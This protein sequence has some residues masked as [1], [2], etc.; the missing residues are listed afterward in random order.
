MYIAEISPPVLRG[1]FSAVPQLGLAIGILLVYCVEA[2]PGSNFSYTALV[3]AAIT[4]LFGLSSLLLLETPRY[5]VKKGKNDKAAVNLKRLRGQYIDIQIE[6]EDTK[7]ILYQET[8]VTMAKFLQ[9]LRNKSVF[10]PLLLLLFVLSFQ[11][12]SGINPLIFYAAPILEQAHVSR[13][14]FTALLA[15]G[16][17]EV[18]TT[19]IT[20]FIIDLFGR[21][22]LLITSSVVMCFSC[23]GLGTHLFFVRQLKDSEV[24][25]SSVDCAHTLPVAVVSIIMLVFGFSLGMG[26][27]PWALI[28][29]IVPLRMR[30]IVGGIVSAVN[31]LF[32]AIVTGSYLEFSDKA[33]EYSAWWTFAALN[34]C[35][36]VFVAVFLPETKGKKLEVIERQIQ[37]KYQLC[38][39]K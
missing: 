35:A 14:Q 26:A 12:L 28:A 39:W 20:V 9:E 31:W 7:N 1:L 5:L 29:E 15:I 18:V 2:L 37:N 24:C 17:T 11:Q 16:I 6:L 22:P 34:L 23:F 27:I 4:V 33:G 8:P 30:G 10:I 13:S 25:S 3:A 36:A 21:K 32:A 38:A 19:C